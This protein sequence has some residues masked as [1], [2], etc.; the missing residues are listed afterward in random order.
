[1][2]KILSFLMLLSSINPVCGQSY[3]SQ[4]YCAILGDAEIKQ[5]YK[6]L[7]HQALR[8]YGVMHAEEV[9]VKKMNTVGQIVALMP[10]ASFT[11]FGFWF[12]EAYLDACSPEERTFQMYHEASH[13]AQKHHQKILKT[14][15]AL[16][17]IAT[18]GLVM[19]HKQ[20]QESK[21]PSAMPITLATGLLTA[22]AIYLG[23]IPNI[24]K[25]QEKEADLGACTLLAASGNVDVVKKRIRYL[26]V[27]GS[28]CSNLWW[29]S[30]NEQAAYLQEALQ[31][32]T[33]S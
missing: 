28:S 10:L 5:E 3:V 7:V 2:K 22:A 17:G 8:A 15:A 27:S 23:I 25:H 1:M 30:D 13:Y 29:F 16:L 12:N 18:I 20:L 26:R 33:I 21:N 9:P 31:K 19:F 11:A 6:D 14:G 32:T 4:L 24:V